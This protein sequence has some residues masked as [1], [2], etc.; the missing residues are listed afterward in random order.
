MVTV[1][2]EATSRRN[3]VIIKIRRILRQKI[4]VESLLVLI[5]INL[6]I[7]MDLGVD[8]AKSVGSIKSIPTGCM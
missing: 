5:I 1:G 6:L 3:G 2:L 7:K 8:T 4:L